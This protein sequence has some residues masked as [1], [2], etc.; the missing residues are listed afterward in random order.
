MIITL[1]GCTATAFIGGLN[2]FKVSKGTVSG[3]DVTIRTS[4]INKDEANIASDTI[5]AEVA[6]KNGYE[7]LSVTVTMGGS[8][9]NNWYNSG[10]VTIPANT[11]VTGDIKISASATAV[12][13]GEVVDPEPEKPGTG[14]PEK[15]GTGDPDVATDN[16]ELMAMVYSLAGNVYVHTEIGNT[17][18]VYT[19]NGQNIF[20]GEATD[21]VTTINAANNSVLLV[22]INGETIKVAIK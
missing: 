16:V 7:S 1:K 10:K 2:F 13:G 6:L 19:V 18:E 20:A 17:I 15:P 5:I 11:T 21:V 14:D 4:T 3:A 22:R 8:S 12:S 9:V